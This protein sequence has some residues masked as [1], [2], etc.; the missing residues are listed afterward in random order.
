MQA[1]AI[2]KHIPVILHGLYLVNMLS[3]PGLAM[4]PLLYLCHRHWNSADPLI[5]CHVRQVLSTSIWF[6]LVFFGGVLLFWSSGEDSPS[7]WTML[8]MYLIVF[9][10][11]FVMVGMVGLAKAISRKP[12]RPYLIGVPY[13]EGDDDLRA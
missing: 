5:Y 10:T 7:H 2:Q 11:T 8:L 3:L 1:V 13:Q 12:Y 4:I 6:L 9:H